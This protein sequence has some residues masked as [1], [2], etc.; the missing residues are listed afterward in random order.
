LNKKRDI[1]LP[2]SENRC[3]N[4]GFAVSRFWKK[5]GKRV[6]ECVT[7]SMSYCS[8]SRMVSRQYRE[9]NPQTLVLLESI[10]VSR[11]SEKGCA[12]KISPGVSH[13]AGIETEVSD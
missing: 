1:A 2:N 9:K 10:A 5:R 6:P 7:V 11:F 12:E 4:W 13:G 8:V 3:H